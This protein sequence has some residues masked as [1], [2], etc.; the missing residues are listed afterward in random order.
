M[1]PSYLH[2]HLAFDDWTARR[3]AH[4]ATYQAQMDAIV[5]RR[6][7][8]QKEPVTD[9]LF[10]YYAFRPAQFLRWS[11]GFG[12]FLEGATPED[13]F[14]HKKLVKHPEGVYLRQMEVT[15]KRRAY[16]CITKCIV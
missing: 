4:K 14:F 13:F 3:A 6:S 12:V 15:Q 8:H 10:E 9:F 11:P 7:R 1:D 2:T 16:V 5:K